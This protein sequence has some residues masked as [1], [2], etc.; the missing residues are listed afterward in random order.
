MA[1]RLFS[2]LCGAPQRMNPD[3]WS[4]LTTY[5]SRDCQLITYDAASETI[6]FRYGSEARPGAI[7]QE[8]IDTASLRALIDT[9]EQQVAKLYKQVDELDQNARN[10]IAAKNTLAAK[11]ALRSKKLAQ[12]TLQQRNAT[13]GQ[14]EEVFVKI[15]R[16]ADQVEIVHVMEAAGRTLKSLNEKTGGVDKVNEV[17][18]ILK[19][20]AMNTDE[21][22]Q[23][24]N[25]D[26]RNAVDEA[27]VDDELE[28]LEESIRK[29][30]AAKEQAAKKAQLDR[31]A[32]ET[33][34]RLA[35]LESPT[36]SEVKES[37]GTEPTQEK[38]V[39]GT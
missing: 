36:K 2:N 37:A 1:L 15:E 20:E 7:S 39:A 31:E 14:L 33:R 23:A 38:A 19:E 4:V 12:S 9:L 16:A 35:A 10:A 22:S 28:K 8:D 26:T 17:M 11:S 32:E 30:K 13:L 3:D 6:K 29:A 5:L 18:D 34:I 27:E 24:I 25:E 21:I